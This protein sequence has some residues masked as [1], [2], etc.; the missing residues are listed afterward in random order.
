MGD[1]NIPLPGLNATQPVV[2]QGLRAYIESFVEEYSVDGLRNDA[3][4]YVVLPLFCGEMG[5]RA[6]FVPGKSLS[7]QY[8][9]PLSGR[10]HLILSWVFL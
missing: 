6:C 10:A 8:L 2:R 9:F 3:A 4:K 7:Q 5:L 1:F